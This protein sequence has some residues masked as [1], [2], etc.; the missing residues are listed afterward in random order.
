MPVAGQLPDGAQ[1]LVYKEGT[2]V[3]FMRKQSHDGDRSCSGTIRAASG[4][5]EHV[6]TVIA[7]SIGLSWNIA[8]TR[9]ERRTPPG[10]C[11]WKDHRDPGPAPRRLSAVAASTPGRHPVDPAR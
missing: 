7:A 10:G 9:A 5:L 2:W 3:R 1:W 8:I 11:L 6:R 4:L